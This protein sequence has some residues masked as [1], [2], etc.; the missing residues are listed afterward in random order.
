MEKL[1]FRL[2]G[3][4]P[5]PEGLVAYLTQHL[6]TRGFKKGEIILR[7]GQICRYIYF[8]ES[9]V[10]RH[11]VDDGRHEITTWLL[12]D[13]DICISIKSFL[14]QV[15]AYDTIEA[16]T[17]T[18]V[19]YISFEELEEGCRLFPE[20]ALIRDRIKSEYYAI[21]DAREPFI[22]SLD[23]MDRYIHLLETAPIF[24]QL[25]EIPELSSYLF[26]TP[27]MLSKIRRELREKRKHP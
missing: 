1:F 4:K 3:G 17:E 13:G 8:I 7:K 15:P 23:P 22:R 19:W 16:Q 6:K 14:D 5:L 11:F 27:K 25:V 20:F 9:G 18:I 12:K 10:L 2:S 21:K 26:M 24:A